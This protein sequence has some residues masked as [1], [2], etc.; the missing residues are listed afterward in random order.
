MSRRSKSEVDVPSF[1]LFTPASELSSLIKKRVQNKNTRA[2]LLL[3]RHVWRLGLRYRVYVRDL[4][5]KPDLVFSSAKVAVFC[6]GDFWHGRNWKEQKKKLKRRENAAYWIP[7]IR[8]NIERDVLQTGTLKRMGWRV[9]RIWE[10]DI[11][12]DPQSYA[13][14]IETLVRKRSK[15][16]KRDLP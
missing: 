10:T 1:N 11:L 12:K 2:E 4:P 3:R 9:V 15:V 16:E 5:G 7:K 6:D 13:L 14:R 8:S